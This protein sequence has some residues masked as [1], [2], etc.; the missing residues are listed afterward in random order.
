M[1]LGGELLDV[2]DASRLTIPVRVD[3]EGER[4]TDR[5]SVV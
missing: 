1:M 3:R 5:K 2:T 4:G